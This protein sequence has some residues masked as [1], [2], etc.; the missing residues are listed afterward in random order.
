M[1]KPV[2][3]QVLSN[4]YS[5][6][7]W[8]ESL[9]DPSFIAVRICLFKIFIGPNRGMDTS[10]QLFMKTMMF[11]FNMYFKTKAVKKNSRI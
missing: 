5:I 8:P 11:S 6:L 1:N 3:V 7:I 4:A 2:A 10:F 9:Y